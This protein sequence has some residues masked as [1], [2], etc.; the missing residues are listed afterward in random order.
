MRAVHA[1]ARVFENG[2]KAAF[3]YGPLVLCAEGADHAFPIAAVRADCCEEALKKAEVIANENLPYA[4]EVLLPAAAALP[5]DTLYSFFA[6][7]TKK[8]TLKLIPY[9]AWGNR[10][11]NDMRVWFPCAP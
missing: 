7:K 6:P 5:E 9:F 11:E 1:D 8:V 2:G 10:G 4:A 3:T